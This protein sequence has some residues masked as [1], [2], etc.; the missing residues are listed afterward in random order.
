M[1]SAAMTAA[2]AVYVTLPSP[3]GA[4]GDDGAGVRVGPDR[5]VWSSGHDEL[6][7]ERPLVPGAVGDLPR[8]GTMVALPRAKSRVTV[9]RSVRARVARAVT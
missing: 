4:P 3:G 5:S 2:L 6:G 1:L 7:V 8:T 9:C